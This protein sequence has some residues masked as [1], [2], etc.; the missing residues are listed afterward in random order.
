MGIFNRDNKSSSII[1]SI[2]NDELYINKK[3]I[4][5]PIAING[6]TDFFGQ[7]T[8]TDG[9]EIFW[10]DLGISTSPQTNG[11][12]NHLSLHT[13]YN[14]MEITSKAE[15]KPFFKGKIIIDGVEIGKKRFDNVTMQKYEVSQFT[16]TGKNSPCLI[17]IAY[18]EI[19]DKQLIK[20]RVVED[21]YRISKIDEDQIEF[22][23]FGFKLSII[24]ELMY[25][26][27][28][29]APKF[30]L[31]EFVEWYD[32]RKIDIDKEGYNPIPEVTQYFKDLPISKKFAPEI[33]EIY[34]DGGNAIYLQLLRFGEGS[35]NYWDI[36]TIADI[37]H[38]PNLKKATLCYAKDDVVD[39][40]NS[41]GIK[42][43]W[44]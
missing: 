36:E 4:Q 21:K 37:K 42:A 29:L 23:D 17:S 41:I 31:N 2:D 18:N 12:T 44:I 35:E 38:F 25:H 27:E 10:K 39:K 32:K 40:M 6:L 11:L 24:Q 26:K 30:D 8:T 43:E 15:Q 34:Q 33:T 7:P 14:P 22:K 3:V 16:Y 20:A 5:F 1:I 9:G 28:I 13:D 19:F